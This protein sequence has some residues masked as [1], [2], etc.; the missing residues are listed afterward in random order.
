MEF[1]YSSYIMK[2]WDGIVFGKMFTSPQT[3]YADF[4]DGQRALTKFKALRMTHGRGHNSDK[5]Q[6]SL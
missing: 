6:Q 1:R 4:S 3:D 2:I 5:A